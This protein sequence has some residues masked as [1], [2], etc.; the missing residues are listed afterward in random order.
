MLDIG[1]RKLEQLTQEFQERGI[2]RKPVM[3]VL[4]EETDVALLVEEHFA[5][6]SDE[7]GRPYDHSQV[8]MSGHQTCVSAD[9]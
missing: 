8:Q 1:R 7:H 9:Y 6:L 4:A 2:P 3:M 5:I